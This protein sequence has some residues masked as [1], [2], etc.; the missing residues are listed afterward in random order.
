MADTNVRL[1]QRDG[2]RAAKNSFKHWKPVCLI[3]LAEGK[4]LWEALAGTRDP[5][6]KAQ[7]NAT[8]ASHQEISE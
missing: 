7:G 6:R 8:V 3:S 1:A 2:S 5:R 4:S